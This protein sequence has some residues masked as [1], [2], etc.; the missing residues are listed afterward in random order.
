MK[1]YERIFSILMKFIIVNMIRLLTA[2][3]LSI[4]NAKKNGTMDGNEKGIQPIQELVCIYFIL[5]SCV[6][7]YFDMSIKLRILC[8][9]NQSFCVC[10]FLFDIIFINAPK[11]GKFV[12]PLWQKLVSRCLTCKGEK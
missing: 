2:T 10:I 12:A 1:R 9:L 5:P 7:Y 8:C 4:S 11:D 6:L 3:L